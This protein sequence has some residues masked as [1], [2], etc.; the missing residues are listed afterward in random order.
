MLGA[1]RKPHLQDDLQRAGDGEQVLGHAAIADIQMERYRGY[2]YC[3]IL[4]STSDVGAGKA[5]QL[6]GWAR[7]HRFCGACGGPLAPH[8]PAG[9]A[10]TV[11]ANGRDT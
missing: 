4:F 10:A 1:R 11:S 6:L 7:T 3:G 2:K 8:R 9:A 5:F